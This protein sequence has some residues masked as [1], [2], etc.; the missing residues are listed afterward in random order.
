VAG[1]VQPFTEHRPH[2]LRL[3]NIRSA[4]R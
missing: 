1:E 2:L 4:L 3:R